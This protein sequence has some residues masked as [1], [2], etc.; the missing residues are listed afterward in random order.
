M[1]SGIDVAALGQ[2]A[3]R[4]DAVVDVV[5][6]PHAVELAHVLAAVAGA[7]AV[8][9][10]DDREAAAGEAVDLHLR[11]PWSPTDVGPPWISTTSGGRSPGGPSE[12]RVGRRVVERVRGLAVGRRELDLF[13]LG[14]VSASRSSSSNCVAQDRCA[15]PAGRI[16]E[17]DDLS[18]VRD[19]LPP[20][21]SRA[22]VRRA[23]WSDSTRRVG[24][25]RSAAAAPSTGCATRRQP[26][27]RRPSA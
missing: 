2:V 22:A 14:E 10:V 21:Y 3:R 23:T 1:R 17:Q 25:L 11:G 16:V 27:R 18:A 7:A 15:R 20:M 13:R 19:Q 8:V 4:G 12:I 6:A 26:R 9:D 24:Q 5:D